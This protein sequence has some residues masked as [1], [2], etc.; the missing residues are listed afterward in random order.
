MKRMLFALAAV[1]A[2]VSA[3]Q[4]GSEKKAQS[5]IAGHVIVIGLDGW[6]TWSFEKGD[7]PFIREK[8]PEDSAGV[9]F[10]IAAQ[11]APLMDGSTVLL[12]SV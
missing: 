9:P 7:T 10:I 11:L 12:Y 8:M 3:C 5:D 1:L 4:S 6:G 2:T